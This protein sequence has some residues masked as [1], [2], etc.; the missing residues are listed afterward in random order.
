[1]YEIIK[2]KGVKFYFKKDLNPLTNE[3]DYHIWLR[4]TVE[5]IE[6]IAAFFNAEKKRYNP[7][8]SRYEIY[9][10]EDDLV[11]Y[12]MY[13]NEQENKVLIITAFRKD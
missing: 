5:P 12:Y 3:Y 11:V 7:K 4:H 2:F 13:Y 8:H 1:M 10:L 6:A 9:S